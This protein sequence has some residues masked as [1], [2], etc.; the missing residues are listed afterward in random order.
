[1]IV[2]LFRRREKAKKGAAELQ[3]LS[4]ETSKAIEKHRRTTSLLTEAL[5]GL[6]HRE[7]NRRQAETKE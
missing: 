7:N 6:V 5:E 4:K 1:M 3:Q 2:R